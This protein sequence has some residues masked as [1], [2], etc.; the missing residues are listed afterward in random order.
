MAPNYSSKTD[1]Q[2]AFASGPSVPPTILRGFYPVNADTSTVD[3][4]EP[5]HG[6]SGFRGSLLPEARLHKIWDTLFPVRLLED[7]AGCDAA[8]CV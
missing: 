7:P 5:G 6:V 3:P 4:L 1:G 2:A 8:G